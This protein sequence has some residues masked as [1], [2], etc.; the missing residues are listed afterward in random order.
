VKV[1]NYGTV[2]RAEVGGATF[3]LGWIPRAVLHDISLR[4]AAFRSQA[5]RRALIALRREATE[6][7]RPPPS[8]DEVRARVV[9]DPEFS[10][11]LQTL[12]AEVV[13]WGVRGHEGVLDESGSAM[14]FEGVDR[15][16][17]GQKFRCASDAMVARYA[18]GGILVDLV[19]AIYDR[20]RLDDESK[21]NSPPPSSSEP[22]PGGGPA[23][24]A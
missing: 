11:G 24:T 1:R 6:D 23:K 5:M 20:N 7:E 14:T 15:E 10:R 22:S 16:F 13:G 19:L 9:S 18:D 2:Q 17:L 4:M 21:K 8:E 3:L 12:N